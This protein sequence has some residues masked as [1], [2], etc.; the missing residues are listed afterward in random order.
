MGGIVDA[1]WW[2]LAECDSSEE[3]SKWHRGFKGRIAERTKEP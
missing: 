3:K 2:V 1:G